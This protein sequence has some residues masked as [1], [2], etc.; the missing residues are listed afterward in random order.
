MKDSDL[1]IAAAVAVGG[2]Y[3]L[4][5]PVAGAVSGTLEGIITPIVKVVQ[6]PFQATVDVAV[7]SGENIVNA[8]G[9]GITRVI[10]D[11]ANI[12]MPTP[13][14]EGWT[15]SETGPPATVPLNASGDLWN[16]LAS[17]SSLSK[18][19]GGSGSIESALSDMPT[20]WSSNFLNKL[21]A[22]K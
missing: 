11:V 8:A 17:F 22:L 2:Y 18:M 10:E 3:F 21:T 7:G 9:S 4:Y 13:S 19:L 1:L 6:N 15:I 20:K 14:L 16:P 5:K 12:F